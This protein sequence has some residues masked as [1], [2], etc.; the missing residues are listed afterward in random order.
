MPHSSNICIRV[1]DMEIRQKEINSLLVFEIK[2]LIAILRVTRSDRLSNIAIRKSLN[3]V[4]TIEEII[5][6][7]QLRSYG[8]VARS[9]DMINASYKLNFTNPIPRGRPLKR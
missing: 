1:R 3:L 2:C 9:R 8:Q 6:K 5:V 4:E 7:R